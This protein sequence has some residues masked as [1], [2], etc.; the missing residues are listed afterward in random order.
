M[1]H[2]QLGQGERSQD[3]TQSLCAGHKEK[4]QL[5]EAEFS[6]GSHT[7]SLKYSGNNIEYFGTNK[8]NN[9]T[10]KHKN[11]QFRVTNEP[12]KILR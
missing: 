7:A 2:Q 3:G 12:S 10:A 6:Q 1:R 4:R 9:L 8:N 5:Y 11:K